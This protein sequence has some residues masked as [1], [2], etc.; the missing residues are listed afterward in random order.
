MGVCCILD[1]DGMCIFVFLLYIVD[2]FD[3]LLVYKFVRRRNY[4][5]EFI[6][7]LYVCVV[8]KDWELV[9]GVENFL[10]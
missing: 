10:K 9:V 4:R 2:I 7:L 3:W 5:D 8:K 1:R 6:D